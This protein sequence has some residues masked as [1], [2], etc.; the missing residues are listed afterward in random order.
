MLPSKSSKPGKESA[1]GKKVVGEVEVLSS[2][3]SKVNM[4]DGRTAADIVDDDE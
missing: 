4:S 2:P 3:S 1:G